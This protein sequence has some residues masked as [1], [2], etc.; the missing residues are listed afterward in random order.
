MSVLHPCRWAPRLLPLVLFCLALGCDSAQQKREAAGRALAAQQNAAAAEALE[1]EQA[2]D[3]SPP[4]TGSPGTTGEKAVSSSVT[5]T[6]ELESPPR[7][8]SPSPQSTTP[9][10]T[11]VALAGDGPWITAEQ[12]PWEAAFLQYVGNAR[13]GYTH[14][15]ISASAL[16]G[17]KQITVQR[18]DSVEFMRAGQ[19][20]RVEIQFESL[21][22]M[23]GGL[24]DFTETTTHG[25]NVTTT[26][27]KLVRQVLKLKTEVAGTIKTQSIPM[28][29]GTWG[30]MGVQAVLMQKPMVRGEKRIIKIFLPQL[31]RIVDTEL[32]A[33]DWET[34]TLPESGHA[35]L[36]PVDIVMMADEDNGV[37]TRNWV[38]AQGEI[39]KTVSLSGLNMSTFRTTVAMIES[40]QAGYEIDDMESFDIPLAGTLPQDSQPQTIVYKV[41]GLGVDPYDL[42]PREGAQ[43]VQSVSARSAALTVQHIA[44][45]DFPAIAAPDNLSDYLAASPFLQTEHPKLKALSLKAAQAE[46]N[47]TDLAL[48]LTQWVFQNMQLEPTL[49]SHFETALEASQSLKGDSTE[50]AVLLA[51]LLRCR[52]IPAR[53]ASGLLASP[54]GKLSFHMWTEAWI[55]D[56]WL[57][58]DATRGGPTNTNYIKLLDSPLSSEN[59][60]GAILPV[61][62]V[63]PKLE[64]GIS[65]V[66]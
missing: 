10:P 41:D 66:E 35:E 52:D 6:A 5:P 45:A 57:P 20:S 36:L 51:T 42:L 64:I 34:T 25:D 31:K 2:G 26:E 28:E 63:M 3:A 11:S 9:P 65:M 30:A 50:C 40:M 32:I 48:E 22:S 13:I 55:D 53:C 12:L 19:L 62:E 29:A 39:Q 49:S 21:E 24:V 15:K 14:F 56:H 1:A 18:T 23:N 59:P 43:A 17:T 37:R 60:Y 61:L 4:A 44:L 38:D 27:G 7:S 8:A 46:L 16:E 47:S 33:G 54:D 58:L